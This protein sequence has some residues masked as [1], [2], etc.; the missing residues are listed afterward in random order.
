MELREHDDLEKPG[1]SAIYSEKLRKRLVSSFLREEKNRREIPSIWPKTMK[2]AKEFCQ[3]LGK[4]QRDILKE[5]FHDAFSHIT[6]EF[7]DAFGEELLLH[8][9]STYSDIGIYIDE[10]LKVIDSMQ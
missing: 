9:T 1:N 6:K 8:S 7:Y 5:D 2:H 10:I 4:H 3:V